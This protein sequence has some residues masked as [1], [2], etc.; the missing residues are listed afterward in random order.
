MLIP[1]HISTGTY[2]C[3]ISNAKG[4]ARCS[5]RLSGTLLFIYPT[6]HNSF[7]SQLQKRL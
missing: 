1:N 3:V 2:E 5:G 6:K 4:E 7:P